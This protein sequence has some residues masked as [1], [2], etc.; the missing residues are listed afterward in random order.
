M[1]I[2]DN[3]HSYSYRLIY[4]CDFFTLSKLY[5]APNLIAIELKCDLEDSDFPNNTIIVDM[6]KEVITNDFINYS[7]VSKV[8]DLLSKNN[9]LV[10]FIASFGRTNYNRG[11]N[12]GK[13]KVQKEL[14]TLLGV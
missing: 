10:E 9:L 12:E 6:G 8:L 14:K 11:L 7:I 4:E 1:K 2:I 3:V 13:S 5:G